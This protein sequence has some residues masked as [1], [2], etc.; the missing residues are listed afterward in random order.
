MSVPLVGGGYA[1][2]IG[3][4]NSNTVQFVMPCANT[5]AANAAQIIQARA[6]VPD[7]NALNWRRLGMGFMG[8]GRQYEFSTAVPDPT[9]SWAVF[10]CNWCDGVRNELFM[11]KIPPLPGS[12]NRMQPGN[13][14]RLLPVTLGPNAELDIARVRFGYGENGNPA[15]FYCTT[16]QE[17]CSTTTNSSMPFGYESEGPVWQSCSSGCTIQVPALA[18]RILYYAVDRKSSSGGRVQL[19]DP[20][21]RAN[22]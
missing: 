18:G 7:P 19:G 10:T 8:P 6:D 9:G 4:C 14:F 21:V 12:T 5:I 22:P 13:D 15:S 1:S 11:A 3:Y 16:R 20:Q 17:N 2:S